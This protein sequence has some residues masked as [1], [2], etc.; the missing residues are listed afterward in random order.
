MGINIGMCG[1]FSKHD[2]LIASLIFNDKILMTFL[3]YLE[4]KQEYLLHYFNIYSGSSG[5]CTKL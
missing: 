4:T 1:Y 3:I 5:H 2:K